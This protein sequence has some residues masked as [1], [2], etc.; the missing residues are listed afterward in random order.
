MKKVH[1]GVIAHLCSLDVRTSIFFVLVDI[2][3]LINN[4]FV[5]FGDIYKGIQL[6]TNHGHDIHLIPRSVHLA[7]G[8][9]CI[10]IHR[11]VRLSV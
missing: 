1:Q 8:L 5:I 3:Q 6:I 9:T 10:C 4:H 7:L 2:Q 11:G